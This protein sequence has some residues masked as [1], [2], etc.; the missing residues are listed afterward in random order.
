MYQYSLTLRKDSYY[1][2]I[3]TIQ[4][5]DVEFGL[6]LLSSESRENFQRSIHAFL[7]KTQ[8]IRIKTV[9]IFLA[10][11]LIASLPFSTFAANLEEERSIA[12]GAHPTGVVPAT[13]TADLIRAEMPF[14]MTYLYG[15]S[16]SHQIDLVKTVGSFQTVTPAYFDIN[17]SGKLVVNRISTQLIESMHSMNIKV[18]PMLSNHWDREAGRLAL[19]DPEGLAQQL[20]AYIEQYDLDGINV[21]IENVTHTERDAYTRLVASLRQRLPAEKEVSVAVAANPNGWNNGWHGSYD[22]QTLAKHADY[23]MIMAYDESWQGSD[24]GPVASYSFVERSIQYALRYAPADKIVLGVPFYGRIWSRDG[25]LKGY[26]ISLD[27]LSRML[28]DF[29]AKLTYSQELQSLKAEF[30]VLQD[31]KGYTINGKPLAAGTYT[32]WLENEQSLKSKIGLIHRYQLK[33]LGSWSLTQASEHILQNLTS[34]LREPYGGSESTPDSEKMYGTVTASSL[35]V[36]REP[37]LQSDTIAYYSRGDTVTILSAINGWYRVLLPDGRTGYVSADYISLEGLPEEP[38]VATRTGYS[39]GSN[40]NVRKAASTS[41]AIL[42]TLSRGQAFTVIGDAQNGWYQVQLANG[43][44]GYV[45][46]QYVS[47][48]KPSTPTTRTGYSTG[49]NVRVRKAA[50]TS[51]A[52]L[53]TLSRGQAFTVIGDAQNGWYQVQLANGT[54]GYVSA[55]YVSFTKPSTP[56]TRT[57]YSTGSNVRVRKTASTSAAILTLLQRGQTFTVIGNAQNGWYQV[58]LANG[59]KGYVSAKYVRLK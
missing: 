53:A 26:G 36:R 38:P 15:G 1:D 21:D 47:F 13:S 44:K 10:G 55:Q 12:G 8:E 57:G 9:K 30:T 31:N 59:T 16:V 23:L 51:A 5:E 7:S 54:K 49:S 43:T 19:K 25:S 56:T 50:S 3:I 11:V 58:Q 29:N 4:P 48:T 6:D 17:A 20:A 35:R 27:V 42:A 32:V 34:W 40:V 18:V 37:S 52:I 39:T 46:A 33:G 45:S 41:A 14:H 2:L 28:P 22:Y 24:P